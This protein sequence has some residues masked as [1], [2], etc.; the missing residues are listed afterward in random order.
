[1]KKISI[2]MLFIFTALTIYGCSKAEIEKNPVIF[3]DSTKSE[4]GT[5][6]TE[7][8]NNEKKPSETTDETSETT[9]ETDA[10]NQTDEISDETI[11]LT[12]ELEG[13]TET[14]NATYFTSKYG[15]RMAYDIDRFTVTNEDGV[16]SF[17]TSNPNPELYPY[18]YLNISRIDQ[19]TL[20]DYV[21]KLK[22]SLSSGYAE[23]RQDDNATV[24]DYNAV[25]FI[26][27]TG[28]DWNSVVRNYYIIESGSS[29]YLL[30]MQYFVEAEEGF[31]TR[32]NAMLDTFTIGKKIY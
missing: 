6:L 16:D 2:I 12:I 29:I 14:I 13:M 24:G 11:T 17:M 7:N 1:M 21:T 22:A 30:E 32:M 9:G 25:H 5:V 20:D 23:V 31:G 18:V 3:E 26:A 8:S 10:N 19:T 4:I 28:Y 15:Y 27:I